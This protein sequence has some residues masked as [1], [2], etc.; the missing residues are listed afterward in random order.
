MELRI[1]R[2]ALHSASSSLMQPLATLV[3]E[4][5]SRFIAAFLL[6]LQLL[7]VQHVQLLHQLSSAPQRR[8]RYFL[9]RLRHLP[10]ELTAFRVRV[11]VD[12]LSEHVTEHL[13]SLI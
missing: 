2:G 3:P 11:Q 12:L 6:R 4:H 5:V 1:R 10:R 7:V 8:R 13:V 9:L